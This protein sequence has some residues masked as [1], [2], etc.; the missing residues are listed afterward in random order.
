[1]AWPVSQRYRDAINSRDQVHVIRVDVCDVQ[2]SVV[3]RDLPINP[4]G[5]VTVD[6]TRQVKRQLSFQVASSPAGA[7]DSFVPVQAG[8][9]LHPA[10]GYELRP[11][12]GPK[13]TDGTEDPIPL[14]V[15]RLSKPNPQDRAGAAGSSGGGSGGILIP[16]TGNDRSAVITRNTYQEP[17]VIADGTDVAA[18]IVALLNAHWPSA[19]PPL[20]FAAVVGGYALPATVFAQTSNQSGSGTSQ[21]AQNDPFKDAVSLAASAGEELFFDEVGRVVLRPIQ[22]PSTNPI[23]ATYQDS[24][25]TVNGV[26]ITAALFDPSN[27][28]DETQQYNG[29]IL[30]CIGPGGPAISVSVWDNDPTSP[31]FVGGPWGEVPYLMTTTLLPNPGLTSVENGQQALTMATAQF[32]LIRRAFSAPAWSCVPDGSI[33]PGDRVEL[34]MARLGVTAPYGVSQMTIPLDVATQQSMGARPQGGV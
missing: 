16:V 34:N 25:T 10:T 30:T 5:Q 9:L 12:R 11:Y 19:Y 4:G 26:P 17:H 8:D 31:T 29:V 33:A 15:F 21:A 23:L 2:G 20:S 14:G 6:E 1:M 32:Q 13:Y 24:V 27:Q 3:Y 22:I 18:A 7:T 28:M